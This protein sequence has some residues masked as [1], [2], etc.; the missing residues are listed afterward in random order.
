MFSSISNTDR[1]GKEGDLVYAQLANFDNKTDATKPQKPASYEPTIYA[2]VEELPPELPG[3]ED[4]D[5]PQP[6]YANL[7]MTVSE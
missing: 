2:D 3:R 4:P 1:E 6:T 5:S 7:K